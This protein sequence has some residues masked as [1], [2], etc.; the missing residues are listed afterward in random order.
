MPEPTN[1]K[2]PEK[3]GFAVPFHTVH[4]SIVP[5]RGLETPQETSGKTAF[6]KLGSANEGAISSSGQNDTPQRKG[7]DPEGDTSLESSHE[8]ESRGGSSRETKSLDVGSDLDEGLAELIALWP[9]INRDARDAILAI[10][11][12]STER[13]VEE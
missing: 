4:L 1:K 2:S 12:G 3:Q 13:P 8:S 7:S 10:A 6:S 9:G 11:R 5:P